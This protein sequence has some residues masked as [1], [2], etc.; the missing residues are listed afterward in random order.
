M[1]AIEN[2]PRRLRDNRDFRFWWGGTVLSAIGDE[3]TLIAFPLLVLFLTGSPTHAGLVGGVA[4][5]P[6]LLLSVPI[7]VLADRTSRRALMLGGSVVS[8]ISITSIP[9]VHLVGELTLPHLYVVAFVNSVAATVYRIADTAALPRIAGEEKL[10]E[11]ASQSETIWGISAIV[12]PPLAGLLFETA[13]PTSPFWIDAV[14]FVAIMV[15]V[16]AIRARLGADKPYPEISWRQDL[17]T[18]ARV[19]L[20][21]PLVRALTIL[22]VAGDFL[23]AGIG[24][25]LIVMVRE[26]GASGLETGTVFTAAAV[27]GILGSMLAG[28][29]E[30]R[31]GMVPAVLTKHWLTAALFP[32]LLVDLPGWATGLIWGL[33]SFQISIL[34]VIQMK[35]LMSVIPNGKLGRVEGFLTFIEQGSLPLGYALTGVLL[36]LLGTT[37]TLLA[38]EAVL[39]VLAVFATVSRGL[40]TP[41]HPDEPARS[42]G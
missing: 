21:R 19:T 8:A 29:V 5:V 27:G 17:A 34:N 38:Y 42:S 18:G 37:S 23:F 32:L 10:G 35:Y 1:A 16:L 6:P 4:A 22:T 2:A 20:S 13:G 31:I 15:C 14:S 28:R 3:V 11:A 36:G 30:D 25:L 39:L 12:A 33:I 40:R 7:G 24:L 41:A 26:N 9:V